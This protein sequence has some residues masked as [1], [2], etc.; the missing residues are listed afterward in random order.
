MLIRVIPAVLVVAAFAASAQPGPRGRGGPGDSRFLG[1]EAGNPGP[2]VK[3]APYSAE[4]TTESIQ[5]LPDGNRI[6][7]TSVVRVFRDAE[8]RT[9]REQS[10]NSIA[11]LPGN[12][13]LPTVV[14]INDPVLGVNYALSPDERTATK[15]SWERREG[16]RG[17]QI[18]SREGLGR[19]DVGRGA[20]RGGDV[21][22]DYPNVKSESL[23]RQVIEGVAADGKKTTMTISAGQIGNE[24]PIHIV[25]EI[26]YS[27]ELRT[28]ILSKRSDPRQGEMT[29]R[30]A[31]INR[32]EP[33]R[34]LFEVPADYSIVKARGGREDGRQ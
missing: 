14:F 22:Q 6:R 16:S 19:K 11:P 3:G 15:S 8:G 2:V 9:R 24:L 21:R 34:S 1:A 27:P 26:W 28:V 20:K 33:A 13:N 5:I 7:Q 4:A 23:G 29:F 10:L 30:L 12:S 18:D 17:P 25:S 32:S 31:N